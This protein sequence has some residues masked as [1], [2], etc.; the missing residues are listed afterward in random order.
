MISQDRVITTPNYWDCE[1]EHNYI[2]PKI[3]KE[4]PI[5]HTHPDKQPDSRVSEVKRMILNNVR[6]K[7]HDHEYLSNG[8]QH[9][10]NSGVSVRNLHRVKGGY[11]ADIVLFLD[12]IQERHNGCEYPDK[13]FKEI[14]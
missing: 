4:C 1:C 3:V 8:I 12:N 6:E 10:N 14:K 9:L 2:H 11:K 5:C 7:I 13:L